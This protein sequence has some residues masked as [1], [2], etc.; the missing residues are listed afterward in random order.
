MVVAAAQ[1]R[2]HITQAQQNMLYEGM[3]AADC[4]QCCTGYHETGESIVCTA[5]RLELRLELPACAPLG[6]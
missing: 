1:E 2:T 6:S 4:K 3:M 5:R